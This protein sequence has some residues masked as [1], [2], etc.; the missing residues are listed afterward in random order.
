MGED[1]GDGVAEENSAKGFI[2][3]SL[4]TGALAVSFTAASGA[5]AELALFE[6]GGKGKEA[7]SLDT[8][9]A[10]KGRMVVRSGG[11]VDRRDESAVLRCAVFL[12][13]AIKGESDGIEDSKD[14]AGLSQRRLGIRTAAIEQ[15]TLSV[16]QPV[17]RA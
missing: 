1:D 14:I 2:R 12:N 16:F 6:I 9:Y 3:P 15:P 4:T 8:L 7:F 17:L 10:G 5:K 11:L 13:I